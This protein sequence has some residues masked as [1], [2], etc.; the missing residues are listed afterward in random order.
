[1]GKIAY[2][3]DRA[4]GDLYKAREALWE[5]SRKRIIWK[6]GVEER[7]EARWRPRQ[8]EEKKKPKVS[9]TLNGNEKFNLACLH[10][11]NWSFYFNDKNGV[12]YFLFQ[13]NIEFGK[14]FPILLWFFFFYS[15][16]YRPAARWWNLPV[17]PPISRAIWGPAYGSTFRKRMKERECVPQR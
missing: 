2:E 8:L 17:W 11:K 16:G 7:S 3:E 1:M 5:R 14:A 6:N 4:Y 10:W 9:L 12:F 13:R 15:S